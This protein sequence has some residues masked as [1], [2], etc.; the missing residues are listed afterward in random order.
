MVYCLGGGKRGLRRDT[1][2]LL[3]IGLFWKWVEGR[4]CSL[5][6]LDG[7]QSVSELNE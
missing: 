2:L 7:E 3:R 1:L 6:D 4:T 5:L